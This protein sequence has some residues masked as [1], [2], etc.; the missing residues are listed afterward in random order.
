MTDAVQQLKVH[1]FPPRNALCEDI[2][3]KLEIL[4]RWRSHNFYCVKTGKPYRCHPGHH[5]AQKYTDC[6]SESSTQEI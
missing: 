6:P 1:V 4:L 5:N 2:Y 3:L